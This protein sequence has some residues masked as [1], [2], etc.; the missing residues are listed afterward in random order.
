MS[1]F[2]SAQ[3]KLRRMG[4][5]QVYKARAVIPL[6]LFSMSFVRRYFLTI[7]VYYLK[8]LTEDG[9]YETALKNWKVKV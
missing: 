9:V 7:D 4:S 3:D 6:G 8:L 1:P 2:G 5:G